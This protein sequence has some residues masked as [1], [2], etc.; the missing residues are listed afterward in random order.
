[1]IT[2][3]AC[4]HSFPENTASREAFEMFHALRDQYADA[5]GMNK[6]D[7]KDTLC[8]LFGVAQEYEEPWNPPRWP[9]VFCRLWGRLFF[10]KSTL[11]Y[12]R[13]EM[14][15][16]IDSTQEAVYSRPL[17]PEEMR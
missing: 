8:V 4:G 2:C 10:R 1:M 7:A 6:V 15:K 9:G 3:P 13:D 5:Q 11:A 12:T 17:T 16:L 14:T